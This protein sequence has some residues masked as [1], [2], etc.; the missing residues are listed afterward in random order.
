MYFW[1]H[2]ALAGREFMEK[3]ELDFAQLCSRPI[4]EMI[5]DQG[6]ENRIQEG[7]FRNPEY[8]YGAK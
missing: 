2:G 4:H 1:T 5:I 6:F 7:A 3:P 8:L